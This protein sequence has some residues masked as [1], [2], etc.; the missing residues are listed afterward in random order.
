MQQS[1][2]GDI[3]Q[4]LNNKLD[5][6]NLDNKKVYTR[7]AKPSLEEVEAYCST[8]HN[9]VNAQKWYDYYSANGWKVG[10]NPMKDWKAAVRTWERGENNGKRNTGTFTP[11]PDEY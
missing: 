8:R 6:D 5:I 4:S 3:Q 2:T 11:Y 9:G 7:F 10:K 1:L